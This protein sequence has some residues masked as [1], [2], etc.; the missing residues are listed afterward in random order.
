MFSVRMTHTISWAL[1]GMR[2]LCRSV[3]I[4]SSLVWSLCACG[5]KGTE[6]DA[7]TAAGTED[8]APAIDTDG[9]G[10]SDCDEI[11]LGTDPSLADT[12]GDGYDDDVEI[13]CHSDPNDPAEVCS[14]C[15]WPHN[16]PGDLVA[17]GNDAGDTI[18]NLT[19]VDQCEEEVRLWDLAGEYHILWMTA[20]W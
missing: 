1:G 16:D 5:A 15:G 14:T 19:F 6:A 20:T 2:M 7:D 8:C 17:T 9:D 11:D 4:R 3:W 13:D 18:A 10:I 12:D